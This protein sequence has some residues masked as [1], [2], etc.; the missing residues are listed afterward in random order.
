MTF[1]RVAVVILALAAILVGFA[2][3]YLR[4]PPASADSIERSPAY[5]SEALLARAWALPVARLYGPQGYLFQQNPSVCG[6]TSVAD[7]LRSEGVAADP[8]AVLNHSGALQVFG[9]L[10]FGLTLDEEAALLE[11]ETG[12]PVHKL[13][14]VSLE[15]FRAE[16]AKSNDPS[17]RIVVNFTRAPLFGRGHGHFAPV[18]GYLPA[19]DLVFVGDVNANYRP[20]LV[21]TTRLFDAQNTINSSSHA[22]RGVLE[23]EAQ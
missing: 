2:G 12:K 16:M 14:D 4:E 18:L 13:R 6:P 7:V 9:I 22:K 5:Q 15:T 11:H 10:P 19:E 21:P 17:R 3:F 23:V 20:W 8:A 1:R